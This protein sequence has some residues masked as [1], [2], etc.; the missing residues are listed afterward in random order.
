[1]PLCGF[2]QKMLDGLQAFNEGL[3]E[4]GLMERS[5]R[6]KQTI[7]DTL[8]AELADMQRF[9]RETSALSDPR[10]R[11]VVEG[12]TIYAQGVYEVM[13]G[14]NV[15]EEY[16]RI[17]TRLNSLF[18]TMD[19]KYYVELEGKADDMKKLVEYLNTQQV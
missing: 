3:V 11:K 15:S 13:Q 1:M 18:E 9:L 14:K 8:G 6:K 2:N 17:V 7:D 19:S 16:Q 5:E 4:H 12:L 10:I